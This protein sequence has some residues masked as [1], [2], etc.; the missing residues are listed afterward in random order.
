M[1]LADFKKILG[2]SNT[3]KS[4]IATFI[5]LFGVFM[6][7]LILSGADSEMDEVGVGGL[8]VLWVLIA[9]CILIGG[10]IL[11]QS[12]KSTMDIKNG[13]HGIVAAINEGNKGY[14][15]WI[16]EHVTS[17]K[18]GGSDHYIYAYADNGQ[19]HTISI[20]KKRVKG[21]FDFLSTHFPNAV[22]GYDDEIAK[23][24]NENLKH[25]KKNNG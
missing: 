7:W 4:I 19:L 23:R 14:L 9:I 13:K 5:L 17:V 11:F 12:I 15:I 16:Y 21:I 2:K 1:E 24:M 20:K 6:L 3:K 8:I 22:L 18:G 10:F 25:I